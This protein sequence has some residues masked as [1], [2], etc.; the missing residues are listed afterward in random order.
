ML[1]QQHNVKDNYGDTTP[2]RESNFREM[3]AGIFAPFE[4]V[5]HPLKERESRVIPYTDRPRNGK[6][7]SWSKGTCYRAHS[8]SIG[9]TRYHSG[10]IM[11]YVLLVDNGSGRSVIKIPAAI[12]ETI[13]DTPSEINQFRALYS[14]YQMSS[15]AFDQGVSETRRTY[16][17]AFLEKRLK[18]RTKNGFVRVDVLAEYASTGV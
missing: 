15:E 4:I 3:R 14:L 17:K 16:S 7:M 9:V 13:I 1:F 18:K 5:L 12:A 8:L 10:E 6:E 2:E 11:S